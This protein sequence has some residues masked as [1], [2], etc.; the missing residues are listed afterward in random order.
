[1]PSNHQSPPSP[2]ALKLSQHQGLF[3]WVNFSHQVAKGLELHLQ[4]QSFQWIFRTDFLSDGLVWSPWSPRDSQESSPAPQFKSINFSALSLLYSPTLTSI[5]DYW[6]TI[7]LTIWT[8]VVGKL[9]SL[10]FNILSR[11]I[12]A[13]LPRSKCLLNSSLQSLSAL[14]L[15]LKKMKSD[16]VS[17]F[18]PFIYHEVMGPDAMIFVFWRNFNFM[19][20]TSL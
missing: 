14:I 17:T 5:H 18:S 9:M 8:F 13:I 20:R 6:K 19:Y 7:A 11:F 1:M 10:P 3:K 2:S 4:H 12:R 16:T 15:E